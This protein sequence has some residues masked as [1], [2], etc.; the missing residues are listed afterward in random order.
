MSHDIRIDEGVERMRQVKDLVPVS[1]TPS[2]MMGSTVDVWRTG[3]GD[4]SDWIDTVYA[5][6]GENNIAFHAVPNDAVDEPTMVWACMIGVMES[7]G[8]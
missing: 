1:A 3:D 2:A 4:V 6:Y 7:Y 8:E 5:T